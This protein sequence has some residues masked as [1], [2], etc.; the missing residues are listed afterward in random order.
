M[1]VTCHFITQEWELSAFVLETKAFELSHMGVN[2]AQQLGDAVDAFAIPNY[3]RV[4]IV[5][6]NASHM[7]LCTETLKEKNGEMG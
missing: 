2:I 5:H 6:D 7:N 3:K 1:A 4:A